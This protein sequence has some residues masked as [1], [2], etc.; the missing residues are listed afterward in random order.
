MSGFV[1]GQIWRS[2][3]NSKLK[4]LAACLADMAND[5]GDGVHPSNEY[6]QWLTGLSHSKIQRCMVTLKKMKILVPV[7]NEAGGRG[8]IPIYRLDLHALPKRPTWQQQKG[9]NLNPFSQRGSKRKGVQKG[10]QNR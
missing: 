3:L 4:P 2:A 10:V 5:H 1:A 8:K 9:R 7:D 6:L